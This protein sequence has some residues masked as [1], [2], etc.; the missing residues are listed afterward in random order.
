MESIYLVPSGARAMK[1][2]SNIVANYVFWCLLALSCAVLLACW[3]LSLLPYN[4]VTHSLSQ[5]I[6]AGRTAKYLTEGMFRR[7]QEMLRILG[8]VLLGVAGSIYFFRTKLILVLERATLYF[9]RDAV[10]LLKRAHAF[11]SG[12]SPLEVLEALAITFVGLLNRLYFLSQPVRFDEAATY[13]DFASK[14]LFLGVSMYPEPNNQVFH[15]ILVHFSTEIF[16]N[17]LWALRL[18]TLLAGTLMVFIAYWTARRI[19]SRAVALVAATLVATSSILV[20]YSTNARGYTIVTC[21]FLV[22]LLSIELLLAKSNALLFALMTVTAAIGFYTVPI[23]LFP[24]GGAIIWLLIRLARQKTSY[25]TLIWKP[26]VV[27]AVCAAVITGILY[28]PILVVSGI[29]TMTAVT[30]GPAYVQ[31]QSLYAFL[32]KNIAMLDQT[33]NLWHRDLPPWFTILLVIGF[34]ISIAAPSSAGQK[35]RSLIAATVLWC[36]SLTSVFRFAPFPRVWL[37]AVPL[38]L[39]STAFGWLSILQRVSFATRPQVLTCR[40]TALCI[41]IFL[42]IR[43][44]SSTSVTDSLETGTLPG[45]EDVATFLIKRKLPLD[46]VIRSAVSNMPLDYWYAK[47]RNIKFT[48][49]PLPPKPNQIWTASAFPMQDGSQARRWWILVNT[50]NADTLP[51]LLRQFSL[52]NA[53]VLDKVRFGPTYLYQIAF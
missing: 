24:F 18:P 49:I 20:E 23:M 15:T 1:V 50:A 4:Q 14:P 21:C 33:W 17:H 52:K 34:L 45:G 8:F 6:G 41:L 46:H 37:F 25:R 29:H 28:I 10:R 27:S 51:G 39:I 35:H 38:F 3:S 13:L 44:I 31:K 48:D 36:I 16:G 9:A 7:Q 5:Q 47:E 2:R 42:S 53:T 11:W 40:V 12:L 26:V 19:Y 43:N 30:T 22:L 32:S